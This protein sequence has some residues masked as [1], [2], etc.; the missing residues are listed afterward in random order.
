MPESARLIVHGEGEVEVDYVIAFLSDLREAYNSILAFDII[1][2][3]VHDWPFP[4]FE[5]VF[6]NQTFFA[7]RGPRR[8]VQIVGEWPLT[9]DQIASMVPLKER[10]I[11]DAV[12]I[13]SPGEWDF[14][15]ALNPFEVLRRYLNDRHERRK[16][17]K[18]RESAEERRLALE[19]LQ[20]ENDFL[21]GRIRVLREAGATD[22]DLAPVLN[23][24]LNRPLNALDRHQDLDV[25]GNAQIG[26][27][28]KS[29]DQPGGGSPRP[30]R[31]KRRIRPLRRP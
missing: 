2:R 16:D 27:P 22:G 3:H 19:N 10:L 21:A 12:T 11:L 13:A 6:G 4:F 5:P 26:L 17:L 25:I 23:R 1:T 7:R 31:P 14:I 30:I 9:S 24:L 29:P 15:G 28:D 18:Y 20:R 8:G